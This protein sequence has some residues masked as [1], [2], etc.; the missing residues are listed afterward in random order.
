MR[1][2]RRI[3][4][5]RNKESHSESSIFKCMDERESKILR[6][7]ISPR[8][9]VGAVITPKSV[10]LRQL[11]SGEERINM[12]FMD[13][14]RDVTYGMRHILFDWIV[15]VCSEFH[16]GPQSLFV[17]CAITDRVCF[18]FFFLPESTIWH[19]KH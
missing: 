8:A 5:L 19:F 17:S 18:C 16:L 10:T 9:L 3:K 12:S 7:T 11:F 14:Q 4:K 13:H 15:D 6:E 2:T 1:A